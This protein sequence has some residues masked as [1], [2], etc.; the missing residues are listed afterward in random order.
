MCVGG[1]GGGPKDRE[2]E[3]LFCPRMWGGVGKYTTVTSFSILLNSAN[4]K[5]K[6]IS[7]GVLFLQKAKEQNIYS[8]SCV[9]IKWK[10]Y[11]QK[12]V[13]WKNYLY[14]KLLINVIK[15]IEVEK[16]KGGN[17]YF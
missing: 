11:A 4:F 15:C 17:E 1:G 16:S 3:K 10:K 8:P 13:T 14:K 9:I 5:L 6:Y 2:T 7:T 12:N